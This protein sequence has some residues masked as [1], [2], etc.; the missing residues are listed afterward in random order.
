MTKQV[1]I[2][3]DY[4]GVD[5]VKGIPT[6]GQLIRFQ[7]QMTKIHSSYKCNIPEAKEHGWSWIMCTDAQWLAKK[8]IDAEVPVPT[9]PGTYAGDTNALTSDLLRCQI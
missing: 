2:K 7:K 5:Q 9:D 6:T 3:Y 4:S 1:E 8:D